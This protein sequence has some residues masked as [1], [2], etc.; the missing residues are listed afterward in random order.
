MHTRTRTGFHM[1]LYDTVGKHLLSFQIIVVPL[2]TAPKL[3][4]WPLLLLLPF[5]Y[6]TVL[7]C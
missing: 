5:L 7:C 3:N 2:N 1:C 4:K 6:R